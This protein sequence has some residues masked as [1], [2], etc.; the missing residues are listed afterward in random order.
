MI[1][2]CRRSLL[3]IDNKPR[4]KKDSNGDFNVTKGSY[5]AAEVCE[6]AE[7]FMLNELSRKFDKDNNGLYKDDGL[8]L[9]KNYNGY[10]ND[11][12]WKEMIDLLKQ[13]HCRLPRY[14]V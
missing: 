1:F 14:N 6:L 11:K 2:H 3:F 12:V 7:F 8:S 4:I 13:H 10:Q 5:T 9:F